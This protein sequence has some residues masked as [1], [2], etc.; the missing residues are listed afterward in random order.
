MAVGGGTGVAVSPGR[1]VGSGVAGSSGGV[2]AVGGTA[3]GCEVAVGAG[4]GSSS[5]PQAT[6]VSK[7]RSKGMAMIKL[8]QN[9]RF[10][11]VSPICDF[12]GFHTGARRQ[13][14]SVTQC[15]SMA[16]SMSRIPSIVV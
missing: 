16:P 13:L 8:G 4:V 2:V 11:M 10:L 7:T 12:C 3:V 15:N 14:E 9:H 1:A 6:A 5:P